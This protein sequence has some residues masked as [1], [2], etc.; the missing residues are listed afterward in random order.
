MYK[1]AKK[2][3]VIKKAAKSA[4]KKYKPVKKVMVKKKRGY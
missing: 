2:A 3:G 1:K 4:T